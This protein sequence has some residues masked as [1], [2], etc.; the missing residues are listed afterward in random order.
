MNTLSEIEEASKEVL[1]ALKQ[2]KDSC[3]KNISY[4]DSQISQLQSQR[5]I[6]IDKLKKIR[7]LE[8]KHE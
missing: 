8:K 6:E 4:I 5:E 1:E 7:L 2:I 3:E